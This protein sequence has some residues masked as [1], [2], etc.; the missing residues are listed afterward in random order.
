MQQ[1]R[2]ASLGRI[3]VTPIILMVAGYLIFGLLGVMAAAVLGAV[4]I[5]VASSRR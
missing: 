3:I 4:W 5:L 1:P 2:K